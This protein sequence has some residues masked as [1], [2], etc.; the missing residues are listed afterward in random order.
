MNSNDA[1]AQAHKDLTPSRKENPLVNL[2]ASVVIPVFI[3]HKFSTKAPI[4]ALLIALALPISYGLWSFYVSRKVNFISILGLINICVTGGFALLQLEGMWFCAKEAAFPFL[5]GCFVFASAFR[6]QPFLKV[7]LVDTGAL[8]TED[9][10]QKIQENG[11]EARLHELVKKATLFFSGTFF[12]SS[13]MNFLIAYRT[14]TKIS[15]TL[16]AAEH[17]AVLNEQI[18]SMTWKGYAMIF[19]PSIFLF[20]IILFFFFKS[21]AKLTGLP[22]EKLVKT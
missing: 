15:P 20:F 11:Q 12:F 22:F 18:A 5:I 8:N 3:L 2:L 13:T 1:A 17:S 19:I 7:M 10:E 4:A 16:T 9:I 14:F 21:L 6:S